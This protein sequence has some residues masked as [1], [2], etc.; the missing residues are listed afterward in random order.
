[1]SQTQYLIVRDLHAPAKIS[2]HLELHSI[3]PSGEPLNEAQHT[4][5]YGADHYQRTVVA[6]P[7]RPGRAHPYPPHCRYITQD[8]QIF[9]DDGRSCIFELTD[10]PPKTKKRATKPTAEPQQRAATGR[11]FDRLWADEVAPMPVW[12]H[13][14]FTTSTST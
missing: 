3:V 13:S 8:K 1:M 6:P 5:L 12:N 4:F 10:Q 2:A 14:V 7:P 11:S 9:A